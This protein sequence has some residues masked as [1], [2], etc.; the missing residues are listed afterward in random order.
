MEGGKWADQGREIERNKSENMWRMK[1][2][3][4]VAGWKV[5]IWRMGRRSAGGVGW[6][7]GGGLMLERWVRSWE[8]YSFASERDILGINRF[9]WYEYLQK[10]DKTFKKG[11]K[12]FLCKQKY[13]MTNCG[14]YLLGLDLL[15]LLNKN[16]FLHNGKKSFVTCNTIC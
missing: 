7:W 1:W 2:G 3:N 9:S 15:H 12:L 5:D 13:H 16:F 11:K 6:G 10:Q 4:E 8:A 14:W